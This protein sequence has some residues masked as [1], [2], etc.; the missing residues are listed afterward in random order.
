MV[1]LGFFPCF[2]L[3]NCVISLFVNENPEIHVCGD[4]LGMIHTFVRYSRCIHN[5]G[6]FNKKIGRSWWK[7]G[8]RDGRLGI[9]HHELGSYTSGSIWGRV[10]VVI[11]RS[12]IYSMKRCWLGSISRTDFLRISILQSSNW[13]FLLDF[14]RC[15][16]CWADE[17]WSFSWLINSKC[18]LM[19]AKG[20]FR[21]FIVNLFPK[22]Y[23][24]D[25]VLY[26]GLAV[27]HYNQIAS[28]SSLW[29][30]LWG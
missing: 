27:S 6:S 3:T 16:W 24:I 8:L 2:F 14:W 9:L 15:V 28:W 7:Q 22:I 18:C 5:C 20:L 29:T 11:C 30:E 13:D 21:S 4:V 25:Y 23:Y 10:T 12:H 1:L 17:K 26:F 19:S